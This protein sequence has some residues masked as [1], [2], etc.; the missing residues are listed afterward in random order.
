MVLSD[1]VFQAAKIVH[2]GYVLDAEMVLLWI[3]LLVFVSLVDKIVISVAVM[4]LIHAPSVL[5]ELI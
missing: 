4:I 5:R 2:Q 1:C 3:K